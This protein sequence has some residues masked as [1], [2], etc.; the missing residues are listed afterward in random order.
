M[1]N[2]TKAIKI[3]IQLEEIVRENE[4]D[5]RPIGKILLETYKDY[6]ELKKFAKI[7]SDVQGIKEGT[8]S[9]IVITHLENVRKKNEEIR[10]TLEELR[11]YVQKLRN[12]YV[13]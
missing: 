1:P 4:K 12:Q 10:K 2:K 6:L 7:L 3:P 8:V 5:D 13:E 11:T 9:N